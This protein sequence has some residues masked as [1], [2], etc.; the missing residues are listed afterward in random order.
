MS[1]AP[2]RPRRHRRPL[3]GWS[4]SPTRH[5][6]TGGSSSCWLSRW[7]GG[8]PDGVSRPNR[9]RS[10]RHDAQQQQQPLLHAEGRPGRH[11]EPGS[12]ARPYRSPSLARTSGRARDWRSQPWARDGAQSDVQL[13][14]SEDPGNQSFNALTTGFPVV[15]ATTPGAPPDELPRLRQ[16]GS[17][18]HRRQRCVLADHCPTAEHQHQ[19]RRYAGRLPHGERPDPGRGRPGGAAARA[20]QRNI[21]QLPAQHALHLGLGGLDGQRPMPGQKTVYFVGVPVTFQTSSAGLACNGP[22]PGQIASES[23]DRLGETVTQLG[24][25]RLQERP[26]GRGGADLQSRFEQQRR[27]S[28]VRVCQWDRRP[29]L[30]RSRLRP[31]RVGLLT[32]E[33]PRWRPTGASVRCDTDCVERGGAGTLAEQGAIDALPGASE[34][35]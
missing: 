15:N 11:A 21:G 32:V 16:L 23:P 24:D 28:T 19:R 33:L 27:R 12:M 18:R 10:G 25:R 34:P 20:V 22:A 9:C 35:G 3:S 31:A 17:E 13:P 7:V 30:Q 2:H 5:R 14:V 1:I 6:A 4:M 29:G 26:R 8:R